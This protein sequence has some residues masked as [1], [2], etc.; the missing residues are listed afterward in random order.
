M[1]P[2]SLDKNDL[3]KRIEQAQKTYKA[4]TERKAKP[5]A[6]S[7]YGTGWKMVLELLG[8]VLVGML[9]GRAFDLVAHTDPWGLLIMLAL[10]F[11]AGLRM[12]FRTA[13]QS[14]ARYDKTNKDAGDQSPADIKGQDSE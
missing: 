9:F 1:A 5:G 14:M 2:S 8:G 11:A 4:K 7:G 10:G 3:G 13:Q 12:M 6:H